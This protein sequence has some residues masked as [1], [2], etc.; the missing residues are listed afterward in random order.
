MVCHSLQFTSDGP[1][2]QNLRFVSVSDKNYYLRY[3]NVKISEQFLR[4]RDQ[5]EYQLTLI[6]FSFKLPVARSGARSNKVDSTD[7][8]P[9]SVERQ[10]ASTKNS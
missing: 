1:Y 6:G 2:I 8:I 4:L 9:K 3:G 5:K 10:I 7:L